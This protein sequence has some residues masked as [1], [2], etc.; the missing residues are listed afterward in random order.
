MD[1]CAVCMG[2]IYV[3]IRIYIYIRIYHDIPRSDVSSPPVLFFAF[4][5]ANFHWFFVNQPRSRKLMRQARRPNPS[6]SD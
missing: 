4:L 1:Q 6:S 5:A 3:Y 2:C